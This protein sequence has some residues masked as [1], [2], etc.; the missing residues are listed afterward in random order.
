MF[1]TAVRK[2]MLVG[3]PR[4]GVGAITQALISGVAGQRFRWRAYNL[5]FTADNRFPKVNYACCGLYV[6]HQWGL[7]LVFPSFF[8]FC[9][10]HV[11]FGLSVTHQWGPF[12][13][14]C[15]SP[16]YCGLS[17]THQWGYFV[18]FPTFLVFVF[19]CCTAIYPVDISGAFCWFVGRFFSFCLS[20]AYCSLSSL[21]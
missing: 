7:F 10:S 19:Q 12:F 4:Q 21:H 20:Q 13:R 16:L 3:A 9:L 1:R 5:R 14:F 15:L 18:L 2:G 8:S 11:C 17:G 6:T